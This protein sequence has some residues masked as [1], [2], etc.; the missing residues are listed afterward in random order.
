MAEGI[1]MSG[2]ETSGDSWDDD[3]GMPSEAV[4]LPGPPLDRAAKAIGLDF[5]KM[6]KAVQLMEK[7]KPT[8]VDP[9]AKQQFEEMRIARQRE[10]LNNQ[11]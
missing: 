1:D 9:S 2:F 3:D 7:K 4:A 8:V 6:A 10:L 11:K 5:S